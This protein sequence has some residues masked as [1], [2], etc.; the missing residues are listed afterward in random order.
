MTRYW[1]G[2][3]LALA[4]LLLGSAWPSTAHHSAG[5]VE[6]AAPAQPVPPPQEAL[7]PAHRYFTDVILVNQYGEKM[8]LYSDLLKGKVVVIHVF[9]TSCEDSCPVVL[10]T[11]LQLQEWLGERLGSAVHLLS[12]TVDPVLDTPARLKDHAERLQVKRG[13]YWLSGEPQNVRWALDKLEPYVEKREEH[14]N[15]IFIG[16]EPTG[17]WKRESG[18]A[19]PQDIMRSLERIL[20]DRGQTMP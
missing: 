6:S 16:N 10:G 14:R 20:Q 4:F 8:Q 13:W 7:T 2:P 15:I 18:L 5:D 9:F 12:I 11:F 1:R 19:R 17:L 3:V